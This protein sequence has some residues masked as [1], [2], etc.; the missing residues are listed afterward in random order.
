MNPS[1]KELFSSV[2]NGELFSS[3]QIVSDVTCWVN[4][5]TKGMIDK[6]ADDSMTD[7][8]AALLNAVAFDAMWKEKYED[9]EIEDDIFINSNKT[10]SDITMLGVMNTHI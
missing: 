1:F 2:F 5:S 6:I 10:E 8:L 9:D 4:K 7:M 3:D